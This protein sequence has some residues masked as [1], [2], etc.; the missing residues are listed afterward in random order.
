MNELLSVLFSW[1]LALFCWAPLGLWLLHML[2]FESTERP[3][4]HFVIA[5]VVGAATNATLLGFIS[6]FQPITFYTSGL[7]AMVGLLIFSKRYRTA[8]RAATRDVLRWNWLSKIG[9]AVLS[10]LTIL[11]TLHV[12]LNND[13]GL[14]Y[15]QFIKW[16][17]SYP[18]VPGLANLH[19]RLGFNSHWHLLNA[20]FNVNHFVPLGTNDLNAL[21]FLLFGVA[22][23]DAANR[24]AKEPSIDNAVWA[25]APLVW[26]LLA[27]FLTSTAPDLPAT[28]LPLLYFTLS[29]GTRR[30]GLLPVVS[31]LMAF[32]IT[33]KVISAIHVLALLPLVFHYWKKKD[34]KPTIIGAAVAL[35]VL[36]P[37]FIRNMIQTGYLIFPMESIDI[38]HFDWK[39]PSE[40]AANARKMVDTHAR[41]GSYDLSL[42]GQPLGSWFHIWLGAQ[43]KTVLAVF[44]VGFAGIALM[45][46]SFF[47]GAFKRMLPQP[48]VVAFIGISAI[49]SVL[50]WW[51]SGPNPRFIYGIVF[52][53]ALMLLAAFMLMLNWSKWLRF[54]PIAALLPFAFILHGM[55]AEPGPKRPTDF[56]QMQHIN[57]QVYYPMGTDKCWDHNLPC[58]NTDRTDLELRGESLR[59]GFRN[60]SVEQY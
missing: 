27:R 15:I 44:A 39:V 34:L 22:S 4:Q 10:L 53:A 1:L 41:T 21:L 3:V 9:L 26:F 5:T 50:F 23:F 37:W 59:E 25:L 47:I 30:E 60:T 28:L 51:I 2:R 43:S 36:I 29:V 20:A 52:F 24:L 6:L 16:M 48:A 33:V 19:D 46:C 35:L 45:S 8:L 17:N 14:Y 40:L 7:L 31:M 12:S 38:F 32:A 58:A 49:I 57:G 55:L 18:V 42:Y 54:M 11:A 13:S 56:S